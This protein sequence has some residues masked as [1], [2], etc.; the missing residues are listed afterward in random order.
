MRLYRPSISDSLKIQVA[1]RQLRE[2][3]APDA[4]LER[5]EK[6]L[7]HYLAKLLVGLATYFGDQFGKLELH[8]RPALTNRHRFIRN[9]KIFYDPPANSIEHLVY[10]PEH[11]HDVE[12][13]VHGIGAQLSDLAIARKR[14]RKERKATRPKHK[15]P[16]RKLRSANRWPKKKAARESG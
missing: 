11:D 3:N 7:P 5:T 6:R 2:F 9:D 15:W 14:K 12:T 4:L 16:S 8:H 1:L 13:R 10:L